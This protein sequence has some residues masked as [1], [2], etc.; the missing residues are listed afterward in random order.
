MCF[1]GQPSGRPAGP[2]HVA[3]R[4]GAALPYARRLRKQMLELTDLF[5]VVA[6]P[7]A[8]HRIEGKRRWRRL[9]AETGRNYRVT[10]R[11]GS[12]SPASGHG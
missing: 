11:T 2:A 12:S 1:R 9:A 4:A 7:G 8:D 3:Q 10:V 6:H 5:D